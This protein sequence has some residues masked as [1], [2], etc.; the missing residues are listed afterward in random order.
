[1]VCRL[2]LRCRRYFRGLVRVLG[3]VDE[4]VQFLEESGAVLFGEGCGASGHEPVLPELVG[5]FT[6]GE[7]VSDGF[8]GE[9]ASF[10]AEHEGSFFE[11]FGGEGD[12]CGDDDF[13]WIYV[14]NDPFVGFVESVSDLHKM[15]RGIVGGAHP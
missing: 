2:N 5:Y 8:F 7:C 4:V 1:M 15:N 14:F 11:A 3:R 13:V 12:I 10:W 6:A 9:C